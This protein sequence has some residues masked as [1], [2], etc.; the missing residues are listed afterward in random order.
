MSGLGVGCHL[1]PRRRQPGGALQ[2]GPLP[3]PPR[4]ASAVLRVH[5]GRVR[6][7]PLA[8][9]ARAVPLPTLRSP[10]HESVP[11]PDILVPRYVCHSGISVFLTGSCSAHVQIQHIITSQIIHR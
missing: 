3:R 2:G 9:G 4:R 8:V 11:V 5:R 1:R 7:E 10:A 6:Q